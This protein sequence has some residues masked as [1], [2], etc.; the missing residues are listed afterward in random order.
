M[1][2]SRLWVFCCLMVGSALWLPGC[3]RPTSSSKPA[4]PQKPPA[5]IVGVCL[6]R[7]DDPWQAQLK[8]DLEA[9]ATK[10]SDLELVVGVAE[11]DAAKQQRQVEQFC[12]DRVAAI[13]IRPVEAQALTAPVA[14][15][16]AAGI[17]VVVMDRALIGDKYTCLIAPDYKQIG[18][19]AGRW[20]NKRLQGKG[21]IVEL[22]GP[23]DSLA[24]EQVHIAFRLEL[25]DPNYRFTFDGHVDP[26][27]TDAAKLMGEALQHVGKIGAL[28]AYDDAAAHA[29]YEVAKTAGREKDV[30]FLSVGGLP[31]QGAAYVAEGILSASILRPT[32]GAEAID[33]VAKALDRQPVPRTIVPPTRTITK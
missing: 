33:A 32:G 17:P 22:R 28:F 25:R 21:T 20:L 18:V 30:L 26:P 3:G 13:I 2:R 4:E 24:D 5:R 23:V 8:A 31:A 1:Q 6:S 16:F 14:K 27:R 19:E 9:A 12:D 11:N 15:A 29:A 10:R 7:L